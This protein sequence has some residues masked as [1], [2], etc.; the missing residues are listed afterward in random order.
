M[1]DKQYITR[2]IYKTFNA[3]ATRTDTHR[4]FFIGS[5]DECAL[6][7]IAWKGSTPEEYIQL[8]RQE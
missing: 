4:Q 6:M 2:W 7:S 8:W 5:Y 3:W 1:K